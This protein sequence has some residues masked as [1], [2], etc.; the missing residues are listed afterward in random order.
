MFFF[1]IRRR[2]FNKSTDYQAKVFRKCKRILPSF[3]HIF[4]LEII[5]KKKSLRKDWYEFEG[6][7]TYNHAYSEVK[8]SRVASTKYVQK[9]NNQN[10]L[11]EKIV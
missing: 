3:M 4:L 9:R 8:A 10:N 2:F 6:A 7:S 11:F 1:F 5:P